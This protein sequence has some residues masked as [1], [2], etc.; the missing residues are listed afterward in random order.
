[1]P[2]ELKC[3]HP[4]KHLAFTLP[5]PWALRWPESEAVNREDVK[6]KQESLGREAEALWFHFSGPI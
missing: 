3:V 6:G 2:K 5:S 1:M 4:E